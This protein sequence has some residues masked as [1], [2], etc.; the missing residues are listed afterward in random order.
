MEITYKITEQEMTEI[1][2]KELGNPV[3]SVTP[4]TDGSFIAKVIQGNK[5][6]E[7]NNSGVDTIREDFTEKFGQEK[8]E[9]ILC[10]F[11]KLFN[12]LK[13]TTI[14][15]YPQSIFFYKEEGDRKVVWMEQDL[16]NEDLWCRWDVFWSFFENGIS[17]GYH[18]T[19]YVVKIMVEHHLKRKVETPICHTGVWS[20]SVEHQLKRKVG[21][22]KYHKAN[23]LVW[24]ETPS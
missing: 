14:P 23:S 8:T 22:P 5:V 9:R 11:E 15:K 7:D 17:I 21:T 20:P 10:F 4:D 16:K 6:P 18:E 2:S 24:G 12:G 13:E 19:Q 3:E 1:L